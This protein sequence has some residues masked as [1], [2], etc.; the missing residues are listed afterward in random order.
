MQRPDLPPAFYNLLTE[1]GFQ[2]VSEHHYMNEEH[3]LVIWLKLVER[4]DIPIPYG[5]IT[6]SLRVLGLG[7]FDNPQALHHVEDLKKKLREVLFPVDAILRTKRLLA[8]I[9]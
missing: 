7:G 5:C 4:F 1:L 6:M 2:H 3:D 8:L 9:E